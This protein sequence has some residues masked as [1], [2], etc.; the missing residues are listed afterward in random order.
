MQHSSAITWVAGPSKVP[1]FCAC[2]FCVFK[3][4]Q[5]LNGYNLSAQ[6]VQARNLDS[7]TPLKK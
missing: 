3:T 6:I 1:S 4:F 2:V 7:K 5:I